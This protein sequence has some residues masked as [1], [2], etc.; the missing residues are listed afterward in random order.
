VVEGAYGTEMEKENKI[1][2][3]NKTMKTLTH[4]KSE[5]MENLRHENKN[6]R[7]EQEASA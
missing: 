7:A 2:K 6:L 5:E 1:K 4:I 3:L